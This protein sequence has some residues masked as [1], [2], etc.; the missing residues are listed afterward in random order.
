MRDPENEFN[1]LI[2]SILVVV[3][4]LIAGALVIGIWIGWRLPR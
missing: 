3:A 2:V 1:R 4:L